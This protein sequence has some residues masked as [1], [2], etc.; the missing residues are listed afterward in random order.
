LLD[1]GD[2]YAAAGWLQSATP[3]YRQYFNWLLNYASNG[4]RYLCQNGVPAWDA[5]ETYQIGAVALHPF[6][7]GT[8]LQSRVANNIGNPGFVNNA[9]NSPYWGYLIDYVDVGTLL[10][11][12]AEYETTAALTNTL[13]SYLT[14]ASFATQIAAYAPLH[15]PT[16]SSAASSTTPATNAGTVTPGLLATCGWVFT[17]LG[18]TLASYV[19]TAALNADLASYAPLNSPALTGAPTTPTPA[20]NANNTQVPNT[21]WVKSL[22]GGSVSLTSPGYAL[23]ADGVF[24]QWG[25]WTAAAQNQYSITFPYTFSQVFTI[26]TTGSPISSS[27]IPITGAQLVG[28]NPITGA[29]IYSSQQNVGGTWYAIGKP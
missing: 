15:A 23:R 29:T 2:P 13:A 1:P 11:Y 14:T 6:S 19:T 4:I 16:L 17:N 21:S 9:V 28:T 10:T 25:S 27:V 3:P 22:V 20:A 7:N 12:L 5:Q 18:A 26:Q 24:E 8:L